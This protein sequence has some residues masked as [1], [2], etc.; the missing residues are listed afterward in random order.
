MQ[1]KCMES[2]VD[3]L[4]SGKKTFISQPSPEQIKR[5]RERERKNQFE[6]FSL[7]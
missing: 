4:G 3:C 7:L 1:K 6:N 5:E 2:S